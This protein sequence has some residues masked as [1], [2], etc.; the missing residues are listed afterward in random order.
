LCSST[1]S[2]LSSCP[3]SYLSRC[4]E[5]SFHPPKMSLGLPI[6]LCYPLSGLYWEHCLSQQI[7]I[8]WNISFCNREYFLIRLPCT[9]S[10]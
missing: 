3:S 9:Y 5:C 10:P 6:I 7:I 4:P 8:L 1:C 2:P